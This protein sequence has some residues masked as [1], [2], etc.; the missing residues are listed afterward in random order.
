MAKQVD[1]FVAVGKPAPRSEG[2]EKTSGQ[3]VYTADKS[4][5][6]MIWGKA[7][8]SPLAHAKIVRID[9]SRAQSLPGV[10]AVI[11]GKDVSDQLVGR[12]LRDMPILAKDR[13]RFI[14]EKVAAVA[15]KDPDLAAEAASRIE[16]E[17]AELPAVFDPLD[18]TA[19]AAPVL[20]PELSS[21]VNVPESLPA[22]PN[23]H[24]RVQWNTGNCAAGFGQSDLIFEQTFSTAR[25]HQGYLE[26]YAGIIALDSAGRILVWSSNKVPFL[27]RRYLSEVLE[28]DEA[29]ILFH[30]TPVGGDFGGKGSL[31]DLPLCYYLAKA[32]G[33]PVKMVMDYYEELCAGNPRHPSIITIKTG[34]KKDGK[35]WARDVKVVFNSGAYAGFKP[36]DA[37]TLPGARHGAGPYLIPNTRV[38]ALS[39]YT[40]SVPCGHM[41]GP[42]EPQLIF[43]VESHM[44]YLAR[45][46]GFDPLEFRRMNILR[47]GHPLPHGTLENDN[48][49]K[50][51]NEIAA[52]KETGTKRAYRG[53]GFAL[54]HKE[55]NIGEANVEVG[56]EEDGMVYVLTTVPETGAGSHTVFRQIAA[57][58]LK[59]SLENVRIA[60]GNTDSFQTDVALGGSRVTYL[61][62][63]AVC[64]AALQLRGRILQRAAAALDCSEDALVLS[65]D[66]VCGPA[67]RAVPLS[68]LAQQARAQQVPL[69]ERYHFAAKERPI[70]V[71]FFGQMV[72]VDVDPDTGQLHINK[73]TTLHDVGTIINTLAHQGQIEGGLIQGLGFATLEELSDEKGKIVPANLGEYKLPSIADIPTNETVIIRDDDG[74]GP[75]GSKPIGESSISPTAPAIA[76]AVYNAI[77]VQIRD[78]PITSERIYAALKQH[79]N[80]PPSR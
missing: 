54:C 64:G 38:E 10:L 15:A 14:G 57:E 52:R 74:P 67:G 76:N 41:R 56:V 21:Y 2:A 31:M 70:A 62:G 61:V 29:Q 55:I 49:E 1:R 43:A 16:V 48:G 47:K 79:R 34:L 23:L 20:H 32:T 28:V 71:S 42:G 6:G 39:V 45:E 72:E 22:L 7:L 73:V 60:T 17:Y 80:K 3:T 25:V 36:S 51:L 44:E 9:T 27:T 8:R 63:Q 33:R 65:G 50:I 4:L 35:L 46:L 75:F 11:T 19:G 69:S 26:T 13:V 37:V 24:S 53:R 18:A 40:N 78:L 58:T 77:G 5:P 30:L 12:R 59:I 66:R 68:V